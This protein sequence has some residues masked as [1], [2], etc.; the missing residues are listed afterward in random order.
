MFLDG[1]LVETNQATG[2]NNGGP[3]RFRLEYK[4]GIVLGRATPVG[5]R[6]A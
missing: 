1:E 3:P 2:G 4:A 6:C 5:P